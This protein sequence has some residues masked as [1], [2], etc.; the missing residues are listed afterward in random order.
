ME[1]GMTIGELHNKLDTD[2]S[3]E[4]ESNG[5]SEEVREAITEAGKSAEGLT[6]LKKLLADKEG[7]EEVYIARSYAYDSGDCIR[8]RLLKLITALEA[9]AKTSDQIRRLLA[10]GQA[11]AK[12]LRAELQIWLKYPNDGDMQ[13]GDLAK[14]KELEIEHMG[15]LVEARK[16]CMEDMKEI[17]TL[18][19]EGEGAGSADSKA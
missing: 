8:E 19:G 2:S 10:D 15:R 14:S 13:P 12:E 7:M 5:L 11:H 16:R 6:H 3:P 9:T 17:R 18:L 1:Q 4:P